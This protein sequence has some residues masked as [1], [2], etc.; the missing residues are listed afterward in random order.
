MC[1]GR[2]CSRTAAANSSGALEGV[3][4]AADLYAGLFAASGNLAP[5]DIE[6]TGVG[7]LREYANV[8]DLPR[9]ADVHFA[10]KCRRP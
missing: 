2:F 8:A 6:V 10:C 4:R 7:D 3:N 5:I 9:I 1:A